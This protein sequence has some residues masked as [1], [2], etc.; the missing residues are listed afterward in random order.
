MMMLESVCILVLLGWCCCR[1]V[2]LSV[3][4]CLELLRNVEWCVWCLFVVSVFVVVLL[5]YCCLGC[6]VWAVVC[7]VA[8]CVVCWWMLWK[9]ECKSSS[10]AVVESVVAECMDCCVLSDE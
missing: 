9:V 3:S 1:S 8:L 4:I 5:V 10:G 7:L 6:L 2:L